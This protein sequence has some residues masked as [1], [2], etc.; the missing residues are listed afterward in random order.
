MGQNPEVKKQNPF[1]VLSYQVP[2]TYLFILNKCL[3]KHLFQIPSKSQQQYNC[4]YNTKYVS[5]INRY[6]ALHL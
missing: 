5:L 4:L 6:L 3:D 2:F 1:L